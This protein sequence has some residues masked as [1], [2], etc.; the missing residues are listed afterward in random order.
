[1]WFAGEAI[2]TFFQSIGIAKQALSVMQDP[3]DVLDPPGALPACC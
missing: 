2:P 3:Q 1:M